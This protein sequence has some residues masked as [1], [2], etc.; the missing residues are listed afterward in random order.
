MEKVPKPQPSRKGKKAWRKNVV[1][2]DIAAGLEAKRESEVLHGDDGSEFV[3]DTLGTSPQ[4][5]T[6][7][8]PAAEILANKSKVAAV[9]QH[10]KKKERVSKARKSLLMALAGRLLTK[11]KAAARLQQDGILRAATHTDLWAEAPAAKSHV[12]NATLPHAPP[13]TVPRTMKMGP[14]KLRARHDDAVH[15]GKS[16]NPLLEAWESLI[17]QEYTIERRHELARQAMEE[18][19]QRIQYLIENLSD[20]EESELE[21][22]EEAEAETSKEADSEKYRLS[23]NPPSA[24][25]VKTKTERNRLARHKKRQELEARLRDVKQKLRDLEKLDDITTEV[26][27]AGTHPSN[28][29]TKPKVRPA[30]HGKHNVGFRPLDVKLADEL[31]NTLRHASP[32]GNLLYDHMYKIQVDGKV[33]ARLVV[34]ARRRYKQKIVRKWSHKG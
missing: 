21:D 27:A 18:H 11:T 6:K 3:I 31:T 16:Y 10:S 26:E 32:E 20:H 23:A 4:H 19:R 14:E 29:E 13:T 5:K 28:R 1:I 12:D 15:A 17:G 30:K 9:P 7:V 34:N 33:E 22:E 24:F 2:S 8:V 25:K